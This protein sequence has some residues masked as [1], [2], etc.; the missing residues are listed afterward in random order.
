[1]KMNKKSLLIGIIIGMGILGMANLVFASIGGN[2][3]PANPLGVEVVVEAGDTL[4]SIAD[5]YNE[6][7]GMSINELLFYIQRENKLDSA[8]VHPGDHIIIPIK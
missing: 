1:M 3:K 7:A 4:W 2:D 6:K 5:R 8:I